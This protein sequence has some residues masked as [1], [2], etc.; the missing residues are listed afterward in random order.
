MVEPLPDLDLDGAFGA[1]FGRFGG[2]PGVLLGEA[3][4]GSSEFYR[5]RRHHTPADRAA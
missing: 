2:V 1:A 4:H 3:T 5:A